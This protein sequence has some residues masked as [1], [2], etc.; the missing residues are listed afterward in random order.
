MADADTHILNGEM[1][2]NIA[3]VHARFIHRKRY[4]AVVCEFQRISE[5][6]YK[7][8]TKLQTVAEYIPML[9]CSLDRK[10]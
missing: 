9:N 8:L 10:I 5:Y 3:V 2:T 7:H 6:V 1:Q 4:S